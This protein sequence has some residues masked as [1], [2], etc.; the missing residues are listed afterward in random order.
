[1][2]HIGDDC[3]GRSASRDHTT[4]GDGGKPKAAGAVVCV[5][6]C[7]R[8]GLPGRLNLIAWHVCH[9]ASGTG[10]PIANPEI[11]YS[12]FQVAICHPMTIRRQCRITR[13]AEIEWRVLVGQVSHI[14][15]RG[16]AVFHAGECKVARRDEACV[17]YVDGRR[18]ECSLGWVTGLK[19]LQNHQAP[20][21]AIGAFKRKVLAVDREHGIL[22]IFN[23]YLSWMQRIG[24]L[25]DAAARLF[26]Q[27]LSWAGAEREIVLGGGVDPG[28]SSC[29][30]QAIPFLRAR[31]VVRRGAGCDWVC[32]EQKLRFE[33]DPVSEFLSYRLFPL[34]R[35][36]AH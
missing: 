34:A 27:C 4:P 31:D 15:L 18:R 24:D 9:A 3:R 33:R 28:G 36:N 14:N 2:L 12:M 21:P 6:H 10:L 32:I 30:R 8:V 16:P 5:D 29:G 35:L 13:F 23:N 19:R 20:S 11:P 26:H 25:G 22:P 1:M 7:L 17:V